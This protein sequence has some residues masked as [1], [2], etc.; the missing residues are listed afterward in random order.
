MIGHGRPLPS[1]LGDQ[2]SAIGARHVHVGDDRVGA[3]AANEVEAGG[4]TRRANDLES[5]VGQ[6]HCHRVA[7]VDVVIDQTDARHAS[8]SLESPSARLNVVRLR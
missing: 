3:V 4:D 6:A 5:G 7:D 2:L 1:R 8:P